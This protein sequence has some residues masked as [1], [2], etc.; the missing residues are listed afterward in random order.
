MMS[1][2]KQARTLIPLYLLPLVL[3]GCNDAPSQVIS[4]PALPIIQRAINSLAPMI[5]GQRNDLLMEQVCALARGERT[6]EQVTQILKKQGID[7][8]RVPVQDHPLSLL[9]TPD[10]SRR[11]TACAAYVASSV[12]TLPKA[13]DFMVEVKSTS[14][15]E[16]NTK[17]LQIDPQKLNR[18]L[19]VQLAVARAD[20]DLF[21]FIALELAKAPGLSLEQYDVKIK[22]LFAGLAPAYLERV[23]ALYTVDQ[24]TRYQL[25]EYSD[26]SFQFT[27]GS[28]YRFELIDGGAHLSLNRISWLGEGQLLGKAYELQVV[29]FDKTWIK[30][31]NEQQVR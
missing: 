11:I 27:S 7:L 21:A 23:K 9:V 15:T 19:G 12:A 13:G 6:P 1:L 4:L 20:A 24:T 18:F 3:S 25:L 30:A 2:L 29:Y 10:S 14:N 22:K 8:S 17:S 28:G 5:E 26:R 16:G 31:L